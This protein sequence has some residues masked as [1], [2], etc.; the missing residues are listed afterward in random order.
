MNEADYAQRAADALAHAPV[1]E[2]PEPQA[3]AERAAI[4]A[5]EQALQRSPRR[6]SPPA[7][8]RWG[9][10]A[11]GLLLV[12]AAALALLR[13][14][15]DAAARVVVAASPVGMF[16]MP[17]GLPQRL[18][19]GVV[20]PQSSRVVT[21]LGGTVALDFSTGT[22]VELSEG[23]EL[24]LDALGDR[25]QLHLASGRVASRVAK[26]GPHGA[27]VIATRDAQIEVKGT[28]FDV[29]VV[30][31]DPSC[32]VASV[33]RVTV[34]E[35]SVA[36]RFDGGEVLLHA[37]ERWP[38]PCFAAAPGEPAPETSSLAAQNDLFAQAAALKRQGDGAGAI[39]LFEHL[40][41]AWP[42]GPLA[43]SAE[44]ERMKLLAARSATDGA[45]AARAYLSHYPKGF[46]RAEAAA[47]L[48]KAK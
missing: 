22:R 24:T 15:S 34:D 35:G 6:G 27:F 18:V 25:Q 11:A 14:H 20:V 40:M 41:E 47:L 28:R 3:A 1:P 42:G 16:T 36:V 44:V 48:Q 45:A 21:P 13:P 29:E 19:A 39:A 5:M 46:A 2:A 38:A 33:T 30:P 43:E 31:R 8:V 10:L 17:G 32:E 12:A 23:A 9:A 4:A 7:W 26:V 37:G